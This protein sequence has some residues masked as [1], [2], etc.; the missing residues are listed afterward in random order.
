MADR[1]LSPVGLI[2][3]P[4][5]LS[6]DIVHNTF[7]QL[8]GFITQEDGGYL[9]NLGFVAVEHAQSLYALL[10]APVSK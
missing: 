3:A 9:T 4:N 8:S 7:L 5:G 1:E 2:D 10:N 6:V